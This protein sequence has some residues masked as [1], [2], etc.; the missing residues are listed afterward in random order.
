MKSLKLLTFGIV[1]GFMATS[2]NNTGKDNPKSVPTDSTNINGTAPA[3]YGPDT[4]ANNPAGAVNSSADTG[5]R[6]N[7]GRAEDT[8]QNSM[9]V[10]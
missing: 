8:L 6:A 10:H 9:P 5:V 1:F 3:Q 4:T 2:C 7:N